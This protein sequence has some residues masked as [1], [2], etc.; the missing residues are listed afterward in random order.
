MDRTNWYFGKQKINV[1]MLSA[2]YEG[3]AIPLL[4][5]LL[6]K[7]G[8]S[9]G[10]EQIELLTGFVNLFGKSC[11]A[12]VLGDREFG[13][14]KLFKWFN[15]EAIPFYIRIKEN[16]IV[17]IGKKKLCKAERLFRHIQCK[18]SEPFGMKI[19]LFDQEVN[20]AG[21]RSERGEL[22]I[23]ATNRL[24]KNAIPIYLR[25]WEIENLFQALKGRGF[26]FEETHITHLDR[27]EKLVALLA[28]GFAWAHKV[29]EWLAEKKPIRLNKFRNSLRPQHSFFRYGLD[30]IRVSISQYSM[31]PRRLIHAVSLIRIT[32]E[33]PCFIG[34]KP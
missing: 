6:P 16:S 4:W 5:T 10:K 3:I 17:R 19:W 26:A 32:S 33:N 1:L 29:G 13:S 9:C 12:G 11:I 7:A 8:N 15:Q 25:R 21:S 22:M 31:H 28:V 27:L 20:L 2:L 24:A 14:G 30:W 34:I 18:T 23:V